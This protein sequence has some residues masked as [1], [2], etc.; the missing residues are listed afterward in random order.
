MAPPVN[1]VYGTQKMI[2]ERALKDAGYSIAAYVPNAFGQAVSKALVQSTQHISRVVAEGMKH[3]VFTSTDLRRANME[4]AEDAQRAIVQGW[5]ARLPLKS[6]P[7]RRGSNPNKD[8]LSG[9]LGEALSSSQMTAGTTDRSISFLNTTVLAT[10]ARH[11]YRVNY[12]AFGYNVPTIRRPKAYPITIDGHTVFTIQDQ[13]EPAANSW[14]PRRFSF[15]D[16]MF[17][18]HLGPADKEGG[19]HR[20]AV[21]TDLGFKALAGNV[22]PTYRKMLF[23]KFQ[24]GGLAERFGQKNIHVKAIIKPG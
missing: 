4:I 3:G 6:A 8:R 15:Q 21:F 20:A 18:P 19:G 11:W 10:E 1:P 2:V 14:L 22:G 23:T 24:R 12:G 17:V 5:R 9:K 7:Y 13:N 16:N